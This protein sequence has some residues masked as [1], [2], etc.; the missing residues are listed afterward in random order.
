MPMP[1]SH[2]HSMPNHSI[3]N[4]DEYRQRC[5]CYANVMSMPMPTNPHTHNDKD[6]DEYACAC[7][8][9]PTDTYADE[10]IHRHRCVC[11]WAEIVREN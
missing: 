9:M 2:S 3:I 1:P 5:E 4:A 8:Y 6:T 10:C 7:M 11:V